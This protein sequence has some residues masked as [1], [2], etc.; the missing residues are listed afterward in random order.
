MT[1][2]QK[3]TI[4]IITLSG[5]LLLWEMISVSGFV[6]ASLFPPPELVAQAAWEMAGNGELAA[7]TL[8][9]LVRLFFGFLLGMLFGIAAGI[10]TG[11]SNIFEE[12]AGK[13]MHFFRFIPPLALVPLAI[14]W[15]GIGETSK[16]GLIMWAA[17]FP[18]WIATFSGI[19]NVNRKH[20]LAAK[21]LG[22]S[23]SRILSEV[24]LPSAA[25]F[26]TAGSRISLGIA[27]SVLVAAEMAGAFA[28]LGFRIA[29]SHLVFRVDKMIVGIIVLGIL[30]LTAD[31][32]FVCATRKLMPWHKKEGN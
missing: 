7:D 24:V 13:L 32:I 1:M 29:L 31:R 10:L 17:F 19:A 26:I 3:T 18:V 28:G 23:R 25:P 20:V 27:F 5:F 21:N 15:L 16:I 12:S 9:S 30:G 2:F 4:G 6:N 22:A 11:M 8:A 14:I